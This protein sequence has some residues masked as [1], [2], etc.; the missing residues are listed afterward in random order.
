MAPSAGITIPILSVAGSHFAWDRRENGGHGDDHANPRL[1]G[2]LQVAQADQTQCDEQEPDTA[3]VSED[4]QCQPDGGEDKERQAEPQRQPRV[5]HKPRR[6][7]DAEVVEEGHAFLDREKLDRPECQEQLHENPQ[8]RHDLDRGI[9][10]LFL[11]EFL[12]ERHSKRHHACPPRGNKVQMMTAWA[13]GGTRYRDCCLLIAVCR[14]KP[15]P[16]L[17]PGNP[18]ARSGA[19]EPKLKRS[20]VILG[21][22]RMRIASLECVGPHQ[23]RCIRPVDGP[24]LGAL[25][26]E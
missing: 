20:P 1:E 15:G 25:P 16:V 24:S 9:L 23:N 11:G 6:Q 13:G 10:F 3:R 8:E 2:Q 17:I 7:Q 4:P 21:N 19:L 5:Y 22:F 14:S 26:R 12:T 18:Q